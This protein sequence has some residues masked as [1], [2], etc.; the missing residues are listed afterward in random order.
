VRFQREKEE[1]KLMRKMGMRLGRILSALLA[2]V[3]AE[4]VAWCGFNCCG[5]ESDAQSIFFSLRE[6]C[7]QAT[8]DLHPRE[9]GIP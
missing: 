7:F 6:T 2:G 1:K 8:C 3:R 5:M 4:A 9:F